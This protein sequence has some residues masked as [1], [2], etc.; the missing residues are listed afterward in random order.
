VAGVFD[1]RR[2]RL[3]DP[4]VIHDYLD[5]TPRAAPH[6]K[7]IVDAARRGE[8][9]IWVATFA[10]VEVAYLASEK[11]TR[12]TEKIITNF[13]EESYIVPVG[14]DPFVSKRARELI[15]TYHISGKDAVHVASA[16]VHGVPIVETFDVSLLKKMANNTEGIIVREPL[17]TG[18]AQMQLGGSTTSTPTRK[19]SRPAPRQSEDLAAARPRKTDGLS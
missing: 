17:M 10:H 15:R 5:G 18:Q 12:K 7:H 14:L 6:A 3:W 16:L 2:G 9:D 8:L 19:S 1:P 13:F 4:C 11:D